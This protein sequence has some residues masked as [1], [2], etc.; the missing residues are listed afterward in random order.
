MTNIGTSYWL[1]KFTLAEQPSTAGAERLG[2]YAQTRDR[3]EL[4]RSGPFW[5]AAPIGGEWQREND[6][7]KLWMRLRAAKCKKEQAKI[8]DDCYECSAQCCRT[9]RT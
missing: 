1:Q 5:G 4:R 8:N 9:S 2:G 7:G 6:F 3:S